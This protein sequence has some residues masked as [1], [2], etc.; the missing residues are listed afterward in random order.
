MDAYGFQPHTPSLMRQPPPKK[1]GVAVTVEYIMNS[2]P[3]KEQ[4]AATIAVVFDLTRKF[5]DEVKSNSKKL[6]RIWKKNKQTIL[7]EICNLQKF[8][9][10]VLL[11]HMKLITEDLKNK[12]KH[13]V[14]KW[15][16]NIWEVLAA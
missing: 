13:L 9:R 8:L 14:G 16:I 7:L 15:K 5:E 1:K 11:V 10:S 6:I 3:T 2:L 4:A 12:G